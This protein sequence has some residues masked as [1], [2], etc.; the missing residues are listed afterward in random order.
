MQNIQSHR[1][2]WPS[3]QKLTLICPWH[4]PLKSTILYHPITWRRP[5]ARGDKST[6]A[7]PK[8]RSSSDFPTSLLKTNKNVLTLLIS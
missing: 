2:V 4:C 8:S 3:Y 7:T 5:E 6:E 1:L